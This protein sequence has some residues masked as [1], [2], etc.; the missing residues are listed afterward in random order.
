MILSSNTQEKKEVSETNGTNELADVEKKE[1]KYNREDMRPFSGGISLGIKKEDDSLDLKTIFRNK[2]NIKRIITYL[3]EYK[4]GGDKEIKA[5]LIRGNI[6]CGKYSL[7][8]ACIKYVNYANT[9]YDTDY[10]SEDLFENLLISSETKG[11]TK[12]FSVQKKAIVIRDIDNSLRSTQ[13]TKFYKFI[14]SSTNT[15]PIFMTSHDKSIG[16]MREVPK[17]ILQIDFENPYVS[18][19]VKIGKN[20]ANEYK[21][22]IAIN[23]L[24]K[25]AKDSQFDIRYF[26]NVIIGLDYLNVKKIRIKD[27][28][29]FVKDFN[30]DTFNAIKYC[31]NREHTFNDKIRLAS[32]YT[33]SIMF[34]NYPAIMD[35]NMDKKTEQNM[36]DSS[37]KIADM[38]CNADIMRDFAYSKQEWDRMEEIYCGIGTFGPLSLLGDFEEEDL[39]YPPSYS[40]VNCSGFKKSYHDSVLLEIIIGKFFN[41]NKFIG[42]REEFKKIIDTVDDPVA[43]YKIGRLGDSNKKKTAFIRVLKREINRIPKKK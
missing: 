1:T 24:E 16:T 42:N 40:K 12:F 39:N 22:N 14:D 21:I 28:T 29:D 19:M 43:S 23:A 7:I 25:I 17:C 13:R 26:E 4:I 41:G 37:S 18:D 11:L 34:Y 27:T 6:G 8:R 2:K 5:I 30:L 9:T 15:L 3:K 20:I 38:C 36:L 31:S 35:K 10:E 33:N 32:T